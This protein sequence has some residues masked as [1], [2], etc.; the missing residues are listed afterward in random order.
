[1]NIENKMRK[2]KENEHDKD[3]KLLMN[4]LKL[5]VKMEGINLS[6]D[7]EEVDEE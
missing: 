5:L 6:P 7:D 3:Q 4:I 1:M 2:L